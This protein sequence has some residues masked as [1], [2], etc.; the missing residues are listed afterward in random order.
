MD[1]IAIITVDLGKC[2]I[3]LIYKPL[4][5]SFVFEEPGNIRD[6]ITRIFWGL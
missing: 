2:S 3:T 5:E 1:N 4:N 6:N